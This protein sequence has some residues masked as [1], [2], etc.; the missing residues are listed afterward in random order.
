[1]TR[2]YVRVI[3]AGH[4]LLLL[5]D[6]TVQYGLSP[7]FRTLHQEPENRLKRQRDYL[8]LHERHISVAVSETQAGVHEVHSDGTTWN[9][10][11]PT[12]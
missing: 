11:D 9:N 2:L 6:G 3:F 5:S 8:T 12:V 10:R 4:A 7:V 1:M